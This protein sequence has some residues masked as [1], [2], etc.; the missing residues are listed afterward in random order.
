MSHPLPAPPFS[1]FRPRTILVA[2]ICAVLA[3][4]VV[5]GEADAAEVI[6]SSSAVAAAAPL[7]TFDRDFS[8]DGMP[9]VLAITST[10]A[11]MMYR[12]AYDSMRGGYLPL[13]G[14]RA[15]VIGSGWSKFDQV[16]S[17]GDF[18]GDGNP[19]L[20]A[21]DRSGGLWLYRGDG[22]GGWLGSAKVGIGWGPFTA[23]IPAG[24]FDANGTNDVFARDRSGRLWLYSGNGTGGFA[25]SRIVGTG[26]GIFS[27]LAGGVDLNRDG[28]SDVV[29]RD[30]YQV[31][32]DGPPAAGDWL[33]HYHGNGAGRWLPGQSQAADTG[34]KKI[35]SI[36]PGGQRALVAR[37]VQGRLW[38]Y[39]LADRGGWQPPLQI[40]SGWGSMRLVG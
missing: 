39:L 37:D 33:F 25:G 4:G 29:G 7:P 27:L 3:I 38:L 9:D 23:L 20:L 35:N 15:S 12:G 31:S 2:L 17:P 34:W 26:W 8:G 32:L 16:F 6:T 5:P 24:D 18:S 40:G 21:R 14:S 36:V 1:L 11:L 10:G 13:S 28:S 22:Y 19:D 30:S